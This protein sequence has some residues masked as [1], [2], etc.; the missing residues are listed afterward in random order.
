MLWSQNG[1]YQYNGFAVTSPFL[2]AEYAWVPL[3]AVKDWMEGKG[4][5]E[6]DGEGGSGGRKVRWDKMYDDSEERGSRSR[7]RLRYYC[8]AGDGIQYIQ[9]RGASRDIRR[10]IRKQWKG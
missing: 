1:G 2:L 4:R 7:W 3:V 8:E 10:Y 9:E 6:E 5:R